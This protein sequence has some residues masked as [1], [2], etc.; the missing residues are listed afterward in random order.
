MLFHHPADLARGRI[1]SWSG[2]QRPAAVLIL[3]FAD[4]EDDMGHSAERRLKIWLGHI[5]L[6]AQVDIR[7]RAASRRVCASRTSC[8]S[9]WT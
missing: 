9:R 3:V 6:I 7:P 5:E 1:T 4:F 8:A 2:D